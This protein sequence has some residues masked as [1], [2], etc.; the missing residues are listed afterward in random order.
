MR[1]SQIPCIKRKK[2]IFQAGANKI[3]GCFGTTRLSPPPLP[4]CS[5]LPWALGWHWASNFRVSAAI[6][7]GTVGHPG[8]AQLTLKHKSQGR[9]QGEEVVLRAPRDGRPSTPIGSIY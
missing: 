9:P 7:L 5:C 8:R 1:E 2:L 3:Y 6:G 4:F